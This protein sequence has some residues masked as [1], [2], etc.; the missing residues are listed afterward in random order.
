[1]D[2]DILAYSFH[3]FKRNGRFHLWA[4]GMLELCIHVFGSFKVYEKV[5][6]YPDVSMGKK[7]AKTPKVNSAKEKNVC[8]DIV[9]GKKKAKGSKAKKASKERAGAVGS[10]AENLTK[11]CGRKVEKIPSEQG[12]CDY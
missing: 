5:V 8:P 10:S 7:K 9:I 11:K 12:M 3:I 1:M 6:G 4:F 2:C